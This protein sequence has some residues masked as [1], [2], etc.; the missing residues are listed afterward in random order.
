MYVKSKLY[1]S[2][3]KRR[4]LVETSFRIQL[5]LRANLAQI[6]VGGFFC[7]TYSFISTFLTASCCVESW[8]TTTSCCL[9][10]CWLSL[11]S[12]SSLSPCIYWVKEM[13]CEQSWSISTSLIRNVSTRSPFFVLTNIYLVSLSAS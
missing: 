11:S 4:L 9:D 6:L 2:M 10:T 5:V 8:F 12:S 13:P 3:A 7:S 1:P